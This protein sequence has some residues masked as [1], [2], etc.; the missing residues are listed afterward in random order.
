MLLIRVCML[1]CVCY[2]YYKLLIIKLLGVNQKWL[3]TNDSVKMSILN[4]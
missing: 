2:G 4:I 3:T 1:K